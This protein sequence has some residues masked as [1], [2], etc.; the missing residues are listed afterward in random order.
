MIGYGIVQDGQWSWTMDIVPIEISSILDEIDKAIEAKLYYLAIV[1]ALSVPDI[2]AC[3]EFDPDEPSWADKKTYSKWCDE[4]ITFDSVAGIDLYYI[5]SGVIHRGHFHHQKSRFN[6]IMFIGPES[7]FKAHDI[8]LTVNPGSSFG[9]IDVKDLRLE[10][11]VLMFDVLRFCGTVSDAARKWSIAKKN[12]S[13][14]Q[15]NLPLL[16]RYRP[17]GLPPFSVG[18]PTIA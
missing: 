15:R 1:V 12:D 3:L 10:G 4:N 9:G 8:M 5:R 7:A 16:V 13:N 11:K 17:N 2:C 18:V 14:V 6:R